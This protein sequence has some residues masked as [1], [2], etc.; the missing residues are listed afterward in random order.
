VDANPRRDMESTMHSWVDE[1]TSIEEDWINSI[2][3]L[4]IE[5]LKLDTADVLSDNE[6]VQ[7]ADKTD[8][9]ES[10]LANIE[11]RISYILKIRPVLFELNSGDRIDEDVFRLNVVRILK[12]L[13]HEHK[14]EVI[15]F[16]YVVLICIG[17]IMKFS[18]INKISMFS[19]Q[20]ADVLLDQLNETNI[21]KVLLHIVTDL[22][23][24]V[25]EFGFTP[26]QLLRL[27]RHAYHQ[28]KYSQ[29]FYDIFEHKKT[30]IGTTLLYKPKQNIIFKGLDLISSKL[31]FTISTF[32][33]LNSSHCYFKSLGNVGKYTFMQLKDSNSDILLE[34]YVENGKLGIATQTEKH[35]FS[36]FQIMLDE[37]YNIS[38]VHVS[39]GSKRLRI[40]VYIDGIHVESK[41][42][43]N[44]FNKGINSPNLKFSFIKNSC[45]SKSNACQLLLL[46]P[47][48]GTG[49]ILEIK[50]LF[51]LDT[52]QYGKWIM[53]LNALSHS[54]SGTLQDSQLSD[55][56]HPSAY[57]YTEL[58]QNYG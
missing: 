47:S 9:G 22:L 21:D 34:Y 51:V 15:K 44:V 20:M 50:S 57:E 25:T 27:Y 16:R 39:E 35:I 46:G 52:V 19:E 42:V 17:Q 30:M 41:I 14:K 12:C 3:N 6:L 26:K 28:D 1:I 7:A 5:C 55:L 29:I 2:L 58:L 23:D 48:K 40:D 49:I 37:I 53:F 36:C 11:E 33:K 32:L 43:I 56:I 8:I 54:Y 13:F 38:Y 24:Q 10:V 18:L 31:S 4:T 45:P